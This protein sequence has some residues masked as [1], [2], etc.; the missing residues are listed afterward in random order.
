[1]SKT[2]NLVIPKTGEYL[3]K[4]ESEILIKYEYEEYKK[5]TAYE[6]MRVFIRR[7]SGYYADETYTW[8]QGMEVPITAIGE[9]LR[10]I[11]HKTG[12]EVV[13]SFTFDD[14]NEIH[15]EVVDDY[16]E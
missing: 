12:R 13:V 2:I 16:R 9:L 15:I 5:Y 1:M 10:Q 14:L 3:P 4:Q 6:M 7:T 8:P 11:Q